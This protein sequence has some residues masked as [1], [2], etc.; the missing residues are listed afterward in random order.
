[1]RERGQTYARFT[2]DRLGDKSSVIDNIAFRD[3][4]FHSNYAGGSGGIVILRNVILKPSPNDSY[5]GFPNCQNM[6]HPLHDIYVK[7]T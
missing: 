7:L 4:A 2:C 6:T 3:L 5:L 1:M